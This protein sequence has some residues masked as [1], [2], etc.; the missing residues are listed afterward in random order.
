GP[1][2]PDE[3]RR[4]EDLLDREPPG[5]QDHARADQRQLGSPP[6]GAEGALGPAGRAVAGTRAAAAG[7]AAG[8]RAEVDAAAQGA[9]REAG[10]AEPA[11]EDAATRA[12]ERD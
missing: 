11:L 9:G 4:R 1:D 5:Q 6:V 3:R 12:G 8:D 10:P 2:Q 7:V